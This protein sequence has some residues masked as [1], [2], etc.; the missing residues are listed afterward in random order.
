MAYRCDWC[1]AEPETTHGRQA[2]AMCWLPH[3]D[4]KFCVTGTACPSCAVIL[5]RGSV[6][7]VKGME[8]AR[9]VAR[10]LTE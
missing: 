10:R 6:Q 5:T 2:F 3:H 1:A 7:E 9:R 4:A 8:L